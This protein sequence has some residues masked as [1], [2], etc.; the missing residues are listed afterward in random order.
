MLNFNEGYLGSMWY[1]GTYEC[2]IALTLVSK[3]H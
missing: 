3:I 2:K 1:V